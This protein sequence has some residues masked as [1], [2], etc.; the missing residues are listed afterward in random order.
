MYIALRSAERFGMSPREWAQQSPVE[1]QR[2]LDYERVR[3]AQEAREL[4][5]LAGA[6]GVN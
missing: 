5:H 1:Q 6:A 2:L 4:A 3:A